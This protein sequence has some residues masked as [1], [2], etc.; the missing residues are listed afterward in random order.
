MNIIIINEHK[1]TSMKYIHWF[2]IIIIKTKHLPKD[3]YTII[4]FEFLAQYMKEIV[5]TVRKMYMLL[6]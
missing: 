5:K 1:I 3:K 2:N 6:L 4:L